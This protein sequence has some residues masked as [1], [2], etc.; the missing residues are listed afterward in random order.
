MTKLLAMTVTE[1][2]GIVTTFGSILGLISGVLLLIQTLNARPILHYDSLS[3][4]E[5]YQSKD[6]GK[7]TTKV[8]IEIRIDNTGERGT[9]IRDLFLTSVSPEKMY[10]IEWFGDM[11]QLKHLSP[12]DSV[13]YDLSMDYVGKGFEDDIKYIFKIVHTHNNKILETVSKLK[14]ESGKTPRVRNN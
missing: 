7:K 9:T 2:V 3:C 8:N 10:P 12:H 1:F 11:T 4:H 5:I 14:K 13:K 6:T